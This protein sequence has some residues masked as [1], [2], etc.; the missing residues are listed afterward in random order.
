MSRPAPLESLELYLSS[1]PDA[2]A[3]CVAYSGGMDSHVLLQAAADLIK[4]VEKLSLRAIHINHGLHPDCDFWAQHCECI[5][6]V[7]DIPL[8][9][10]R[11]VVD[12]AGGDGP[13]AS[14]RMARYSAF[15]NILQDNEHLLLAQH[16]D[17]QA[18]TF[19][20]QALRGSGPDGLASI[21]RKRVFAKGIMARPLLVCNQ[22][23][24]RDFA[25]CR[26]LS[27]VEDPSNQDTGFDRNFLRKNVLPML[28]SR[29]PAVSHTLSRAAMR[30]AAASQTLLGLA[31]EDL[32]GVRVRGC[33]ELSVS[34]VKSLPRERAFNVLR[35]WVRQAGKRMPRLQDLSQ[36]LSDLV[37]ARADSA[38]VVNV[39]DYEFRRHRDR[40]YLLS[41]HIDVEPFFYEW[42]APFENLHITEI[43]QTINATACAAQGIA[44]PSA[45]CL[46]VRSRSGGE[47]I[48]LGEP[49]FHKAVKKVLQ[50]SAVPPWQRDS[51]PLIYSNGR[52]A[53]VWNI[54]VAVDFR[55]SSII[56]AELA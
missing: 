44:L 41:P 23:S 12:D 43:D 15:A 48:K 2:V 3:F 17:D 13:E 50:E 37:G 9:I 39:R 11:V 19:L 31:Q 34:E 6:N 36:V 1:Q 7:L 28:K 53:A 30:S 14:A 16:A 26:G 21:P 4:D 5:C 49:A 22:V 52:L 47:L 55:R 29:W 18:E 10:Q 40:L 25:A 32:D 24:L 46:I 45:G 33:A 8:S 51:I 42:H 20:L 38:G 56:D 27:W 54:A 35:L